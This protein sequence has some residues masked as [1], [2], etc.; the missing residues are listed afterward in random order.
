MSSHREAP[1]I[2]QGPGGRQ[3]RPLRV[4]QPGQAR[5]RHD[6]RQLHPAARTRRPARTS[7]SSATTCSTRSTSTTTATA[8]RHHLQVPLH[9]ARRAT[10][11]RSSTT[12]VRSRR[13]TAQL[14]PAPDLL[15]HQGGA[16]GK[17]GRSSATDLPCPP[18]NI[19]PR[20]TPNYA[21]ARRARPCTR[22]RAATRCSPASA[23]TASTS[24]SARSSTWAT[25]GRSR[26]CTCIPTRRGAPA[27]TRSRERSTCTRIAL[28]VP[29]TELTARRHTPDRLPKPRR[30]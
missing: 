20:S 7:S 4:R 17:D 1:E 15:R 6:H 21:G 13:S 26:T 12:P 11:R 8:R 22:C 9:D 16:K 24:T 27:S 3:H 14:E 2:S 5:P 28:Q 25:C 23:P 19:G 30:R 10:P 29:M 18:C